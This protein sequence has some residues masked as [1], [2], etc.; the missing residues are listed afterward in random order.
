MK[1]K[2]SV[3]T[4]SEIKEYRVKKKYRVYI[5]KR[6]LQG[7]A[8]VSMRNLKEYET[9]ENE[10]AKLCLY[11]REDGHVNRDCELRL[12]EEEEKRENNTGKIRT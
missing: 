4:M 3:A 5:P 11:C 6:L 10:I 7:S 2:N 12:E 1:E 8:N 9:P